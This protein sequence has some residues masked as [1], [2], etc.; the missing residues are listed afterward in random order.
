MVSTVRLVFLARHFCIFARRQLRWQVDLGDMQTR[1]GWG[2]AVTTAIADDK[3][4]VNWDHEKGSF[5]TALD[6]ATGKAL[7]RVERSE[8]VTSWNTPLI[9]KDGSRLWLW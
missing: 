9:V 5:I 4:I 6:A 1:F 3:L 8:E 7:W 2:E